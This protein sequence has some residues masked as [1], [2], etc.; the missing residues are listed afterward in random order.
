MYTLNLTKLEFLII[1]IVVIFIFGLIYKKY[2]DE[3]NF[4]F[5]N[6]KK[7][8]DLTDAIYYSANTHITIG[9]NDIHP[10]TKFIKKI[11]ILQI[12]ILLITIVILSSCNK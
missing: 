5:L 9:N 6:K 4:I 7:Q 10:K 1:N 3:K 12:F 8:M 2:G 11:I